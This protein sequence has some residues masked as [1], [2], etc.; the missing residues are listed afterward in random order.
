MNFTLIISSSYAEHARGTLKVRFSYVEI[1]W[2][3]KAS[4]RGAYNEGMSNEW[5]TL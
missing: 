1:E 3:R 4:V 2:V 5:L